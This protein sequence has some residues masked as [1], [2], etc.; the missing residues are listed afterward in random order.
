M[1]WQSG[2]YASN[3]KEGFVTLVKEGLAAHF[4]ERVLNFRLQV[5]KAPS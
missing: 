2:D 4:Q 3:R 1:I 5:D